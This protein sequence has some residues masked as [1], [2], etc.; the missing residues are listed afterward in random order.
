MLL[1]WPLNEP[2]PL[3]VGAELQDRQRAGGGVDGDGHADTGVAARQLL[4]DEDV[5]EEVRARP[6]VLLRHAD[7][8]EAEIGELREHLAREPVR[9]IPL[10]CV[11]LDLRPRQLPRDGLDLAL[12]RRELEL[13]ARQ[14]TPGGRTPVRPAISLPAPACSRRRTASG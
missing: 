5:R 4:E 8:E 7:A 9:A 3:L 1:P 14:T 12:L 11:G 2:A 10:G 13:H 6:A